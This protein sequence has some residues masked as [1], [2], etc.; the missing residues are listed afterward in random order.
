MSENLSCLKPRTCKLC[1]FR[2]RESGCKL[3]EGN[4]YYRPKVKET[5]SE[6]DGCPYRRDSPRRPCV[7]I[8]CQL[9]GS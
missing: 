4:C 9:L 6:C 2:H 8:I 3:G 5:R 7:L 1:Y